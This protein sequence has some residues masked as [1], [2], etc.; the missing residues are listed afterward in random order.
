VNATTPGSATAPRARMFD[1]NAWH[2]R[3]PALHEA[4][5]RRSGPVWW[6][7]TCASRPRQ[8]PHRRVVLSNSLHR[9]CT[10]SA[11]QE[12]ASSMHQTCIGLHR[13]SKAAFDGRFWVH[14]SLRRSA[15]T[16]AEQPLT[17]TQLHVRFFPTDCTSRIGR[18]FMVHCAR[19]LQRMIGPAAVR[20]EYGLRQ[21]CCLQ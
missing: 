1:V 8:S 5:H 2:R 9:P 16:D 15:S 17:R 14:P 4:Q 13:P 20:F 21:A 18:R 3:R 19:A 6:T 7:I 11:R 12:I 10:S